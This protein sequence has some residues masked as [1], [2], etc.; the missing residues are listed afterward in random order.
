MAHEE[1]IICSLNPNFDSKMLLHNNTRPVRF[2][3]HEEVFNKSEAFLLM[4]LNC[5]E[6][7]VIDEIGIIEGHWN[8][9]KQILNTWKMFEK[10]TLVL[11]VRQDVFEKIHEQIKQEE[12][13]EVLVYIIYRNSANDIINEIVNS[14]L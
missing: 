2:L 7:I 10:L 5:A 8:I 14:K 9:V 6:I 13:E 12:N 11:C 1:A 4:H 3:V